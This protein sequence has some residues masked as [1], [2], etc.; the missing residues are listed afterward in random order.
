MSRERN[1]PRPRD[2][3]PEILA[4]PGAPLQKLCIKLKSSLVQK[5]LKTST[6]RQF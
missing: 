5:Q 1:G 4:A 6:Y 3:A 2:P